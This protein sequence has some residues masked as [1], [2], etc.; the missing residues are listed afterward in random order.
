MILDTS[1]ILTILRDEPEAA[2]F[3]K[4]SEEVVV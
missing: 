1:V 3:A 2:E 4:G